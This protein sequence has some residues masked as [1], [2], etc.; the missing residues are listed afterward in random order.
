M[1]VMDLHKTGLHNVFSTLEIIFCAFL[2]LKG[3]LKRVAENY[4][5]KALIPFIGV[6]NR[7][8]FVTASYA[9]HGISMLQLFYYNGLAPTV[10]FAMSRK[11]ILMH[12]RLQ[13][14]KFK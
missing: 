7:Y 14:E 13:S 10:K 6:R 2:P 3:V 12:C 8:E 9:G 1:D 11:L 4:F 5:V